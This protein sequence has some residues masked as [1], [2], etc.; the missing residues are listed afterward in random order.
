M[1]SFR[2]GHRAT[3]CHWLGW[4]TNCTRPALPPPHRRPP[5]LL[6]TITLRWGESVTD[7]SQ[8]LVAQHGG[9]R[10]LFR[11]NVAELTQKDL[12]LVNRKRDEVSLG[13]SQAHDPGRCC[14][15]H[16]AVRGEGQP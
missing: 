16:T 3:S 9:L 1:P 11:L 7:V 6:S 12:S 4:Q 10:G 13:P 5:H 15:Q 8:R 2:L 14:G